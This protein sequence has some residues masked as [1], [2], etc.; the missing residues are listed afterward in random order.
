VEA[1]DGKDLPGSDGVVAYLYFSDFNSFVLFSGKF[2]INT[3]FIF[4]GIAIIIAIVIHLLGWDIIL[5]KDIHSYGIFGS[6]LVGAFYTFGL[7]TPTAMVLIVE[8]MRMNNFLLT[9]A[10]AAFSAAIVDTALF[11]LLRGPLEKN[12]GTLLTGINNKFGKFRPAYPIVGFFIF[13]LPLPD[14]LG[15]ALMEITSINPRSI[16]ILVFFAKLIT[17]ILAYGAIVII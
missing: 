16:F 13:G 9:A 5:A 12:A 10:T 8:I 15:I 6:F 11:M 2:P 1:E 7:T 4:V 14:E 3:R 17:L